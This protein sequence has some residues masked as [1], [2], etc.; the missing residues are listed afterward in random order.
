MEITTGNASVE[1]RCALT[2]ALIVRGIRRMT[3][4]K[5][6]YI[7]LLVL[8]LVWA[9]PCMA[10]DG[11][12]TDAYRE[13]YEQSQRIRERQQDYIIQKNE[14]ER[15]QAEFE[16]NYNRN[17]SGAK[18]RYNVDTDESYWEFDNGIVIEDD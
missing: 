3:M 4:F 2:H 8:C 1:N 6:A 18:W 13:V 16:R 7:M 15:N 9:V 14:I 5:Y 17:D 11:T 10:G 12:L